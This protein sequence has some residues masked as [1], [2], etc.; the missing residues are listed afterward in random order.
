MP[1]WVQNGYTEYAKRLPKSCSIK[2]VELAMATRG[3]TG[4]V[5][6]YQQNEL[7]RIENTIPKRAKII[8]L[9]E[10]GQQTTSLQLAKKLADWLASGQDI[11]LIVG[12]P[13]GLH[14]SLLQKAE[15]AWGLS[16]LTLPH[17]MVRIIVAEQL[18]RSWSVLQKHPY[19]RE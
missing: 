18:Y 8:V 14:T 4:S 6:K 5:A 17:S 9:D 10:Q 2:L 11:A 19:H 1:K 3:K 12:G 7:K 13:D 16:K 15:W